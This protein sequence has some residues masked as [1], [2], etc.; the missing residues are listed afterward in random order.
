MFANVAQ[1]AGP[2]QKGFLHD[3]TQEVRAACI[4]V[5]VVQCGQCGKRTQDNPVVRMV[6]VL[7]A[8]IVRAAGNLQHSQ[9][10]SL[11]SMLSAHLSDTLT[12]C[13]PSRVRPPA[14]HPCTP[15]QHANLPHP[16]PCSVAALVLHRR[17]L[18][19]I[20]CMK[21]SPPHNARTPCS[22][23]CISREC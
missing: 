17:L 7:P 8:A 18:C 15:M 9:Q 16:V 6:Q 14:A 13:Q 11:E 20:A 4:C 3:G 12:I 5:Q 1:N 10:P 19:W 21:C 2:L 23:S 22:S